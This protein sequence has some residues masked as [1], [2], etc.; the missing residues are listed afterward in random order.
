MTTDKVPKLAEAHGAFDDGTKFHIWGAAKGSGMIAPNMATMLGFILT[1]ARLDSNLMHVLIKKNAEATFNRVTVDGDTSTNDT[2][3]FLASGAAGGPLISKVSQAECFEKPL[4]TV[5]NTLARMIAKDGEGATRLVEIA[6]LGAKTLPQAQKAARTVAESPLVKTAFFGADANWGRILAALG[7]S[8]ASFDP[9]RV[10]LDLNDVP[11][12]RNGQ[13]NDQETAAS[14]VM[15]KPE[16][17]L[18]I[19]LNA[20]QHHYEMLTCDFSHEYVDINGSYR[21]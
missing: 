16:Y 18:T 2:L 11:W 8:G 14:E 5:L 13:D 21:S 17:L 7:R 19:N 9:Y 12:V 1:D 3:L 20:G 6:V 4:F 15:K 10:D